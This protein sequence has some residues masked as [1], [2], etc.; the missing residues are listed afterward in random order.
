MAA[1]V[2]A[3]GVCVLYQGQLL[4]GAVRERHPQWHNHG[5]ARISVDKGSQYA[6]RA[7][8]Q[9]PLCRWHFSLGKS[10]ARACQAGAVVVYAVAGQ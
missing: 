10:R 5:C 1:S 7:G 9:G 6:R 4:V 3:G 2:L 8:G